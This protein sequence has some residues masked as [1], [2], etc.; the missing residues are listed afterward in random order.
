MEPDVYTA[1]RKLDAWLGANSIEGG[2]IKNKEPLCIKAGPAAV[3]SKADEVADSDIES[4]SGRDSNSEDTTARNPY[5][6]LRQ[7]T[8]LEL[9]VLNK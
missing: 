1:S 4:E 9:F 3:I 5:Q 6:P 7:L 2:S 8:L